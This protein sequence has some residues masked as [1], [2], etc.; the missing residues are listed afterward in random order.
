[1]KVLLNATTLNKGGALQ[2]SVSFIQEALRADD[3][4]D[5]SFAVSEAVYRELRTF[6]PA[7]QLSRFEVYGQTPARFAEARRRL[8]EFERYSGVDLVFTFFGPAY[9]TFS[10][11]HVCGMADGWVSHAGIAAL[12]GLG[13]SRSLLELPLRIL[14]KAFWFRKANAWVV[15]AEVA[16]VGL[17][18]RFNFPLDK[19]FVVPNNCGLHYLDNACHYSTLDNATTVKI[20]CLSAYYPHKNIELVP[21]VAKELL[22]LRPELLFEF[23]LTLPENSKDTHRIF[24]MARALGVA[25][26][27]KNV[28]PVSVINCPA[29]Y[30]SCHISFLPSLL[31][32]FSANYP[33]A[34]AM[35][36][37]VVTTDM[38]FSRSICAD[39]A[40]YFRPMN[41]F[42]AAG[43][44]LKLI[45]NK[46][47]WARLVGKGKKV[48]AGLPTPT[49]KYAMY[50]ACLK[51]M[52]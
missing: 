50:C 21:L 15:E 10:G 27:V 23:V 28:G 18:R 35:G 49:E 25:N 44:L 43:V 46:T 12:K 42:A 16:R 6:V 7:T 39:A 14:H 41:A 52:V 38:E 22:K 45:D 2:A 26:Y 36:L 32:T 17:H 34:M 13:L 1:M 47:E 24:E 40:L 4:I 30:R 11:L 9:V 5:W 37:P 20:L 29:L 48:L 3:D 31:E 33:E 19:I 51:S 8:K